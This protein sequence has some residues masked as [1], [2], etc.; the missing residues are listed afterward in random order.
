MK[1][2]KSAGRDD[3]AVVHIADIG[4]GRLVEFA[5]SV[6][7]PI[8][9]EK[10]W[11]LMISSLAGCPVGCLMCDAGGDYR[12][13]LS[14]AEMLGQIDYLVGKRFPGGAVPVEKFKVQFARIGDPALNPAV[15]EALEG[16]PGRYA[17]PG[18]I[19]CLST[20]APRGCDAFFDRL[21][22]LKRR[23]YGGGKFQLQFSIH[24]TDERERDR[25]IPVK[26]WSFE[27][28]AEYGGRFHEDGGRKIG[29]NFALGRGVPADSDVLIRYFSPDIFMIKITP[30]N[31]TCAA[32][33]HQL[34]SY[35]DSSSAES[36][37]DVVAKMRAAGYEVIVSIGDSR[38]NQIGS[39]C[40]QFVT[41]YLREKKSLRGKAASYAYWKKR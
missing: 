32:A 22:D 14:A 19:A 27:Q 31:P 17:A 7:P 26:K 18:L 25:I 3:V 10:K 13:R 9:R 21:L 12:G 2:L 23:R 33:A 35:I 34:G 5:E 36:D 39:N 30:V 8:P 41:R 15:L 28:I 20:V 40:G 37:Y 29:L 24:S 38:E 6:Q 4:D 16:L 1:I 11:V